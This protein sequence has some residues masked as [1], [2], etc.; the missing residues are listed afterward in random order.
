MNDYTL[1]LFKLTHLNINIEKS[2]ETIINE[3][4]TTLDIYL[5]LSTFICPHCNSKDIKIVSSVTSK[6]NYT[7]FVDH[8]TTI[9]L[10]RRK[11]QCLSCKKFFLEV[12]PIVSYNRNI[13]F[14]TDLRILELLK[15][16]SMTYSKAACLT[17][18]SPSYVQSVFDNR[19]SF[20]LGK[21]SSVICIDEVYAKRLVKNRYICVLINPFDKSA[22][23]IFSSRR[24]QDL[25][26]FTAQYSIS[27]R[28]KVKYVSIDLGDTYR[29]VA[30]T[31]FPNCI[32]CADS[33]H[34][35]KNL[36]FYFNK[37][38]IS[39]LKKYEYLKKERSSLYWL[40]KKY[41]FVLYKDFLKLKE[42]YCI[43]KAT[44]ELMSKYQ[45]RS[46]ILSIDSNFQKAYDLKEAYR[47]FNSSASIL[48][49][50]DRLSDLIQEFSVSKIP[51]YIPFVHLLKNW[52]KE[53][54]NSFSAYNGHRIH[55]GYI[56]RR[57]LVIK[58]LF[59]N[60]YGFYNFPRTRNRILYV[61]NHDS[62]IRGSNV[63]IS[64]TLPGKPRGK[65][66]K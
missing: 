40:L 11:F 55:N 12:N 66:K 57:N 43:N 37:I 35:I 54:V 21:L 7:I 32:V 25:F 64:N 59:T 14:N 49:A 42:Y 33:F 22:I 17:S 44:G 18:T 34:V 5:N 13:S 58:Q 4:E 16:P 45:I 23:D 15:E 24:K 47:S 20:G 9:V 65:Y 48:D 60:A 8:K 50:E 56:E 52:K 10:H 30:Q 1:K 6:I 41:N 2:F 51:E 26:N 31:V 27:E 63:K 46:T 36:M 28:L 19:I 38:R 3:D 39:F 62:V 53:I 61:L 29:T